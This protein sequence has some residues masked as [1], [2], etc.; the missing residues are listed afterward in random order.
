MTLKGYAWNFFHRNGI[1][2]VL[3]KTKFKLYGV[4]FS[5]V[6]FHGP[7]EVRRFGESIIDIGNGSSFGGNCQIWAEK[8]VIEVGSNLQCENFTRL[9]ASAG[10]KISIGDNVYVGLFSIITAFENITVG[11]N[12]MIAHHCHIIDFNHGMAKNKLMRKQLDMTKPVFIGNDVWIGSG[13]VIMKG[14]S[15][16]DGAVVGAGSV[17]TKDVAPY[18]IVAGVSARLIRQRQ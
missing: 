3:G 2:S 17:V 13:A 11:S 6:T 18:S 16:G 12:S 14:V 9:H 1:H 8:G 10:G 4:K 15:I 5:N 7:I